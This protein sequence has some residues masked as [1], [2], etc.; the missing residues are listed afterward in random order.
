MRKM[1]DFLGLVA[2]GVILLAAAIGT[3]AFGI[4]VYYTFNGR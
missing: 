1:T 4:V 2:Y 3:C